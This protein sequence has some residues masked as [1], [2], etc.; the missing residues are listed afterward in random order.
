MK[1]FLEGLTKNTDYMTKQVKDYVN[2]FVKTFRKEFKSVTGT[3][4]TGITKKV[5]EVSKTTKQSKIS[6]NSKMV[7]NNYNLTQNNTSPKSLSALETYRA[8]QQ[9]ISLVKAL[10]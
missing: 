9:Q 1:S 3:D 2:A 5:S 6:G 8:R 7:T 10:T 4:L